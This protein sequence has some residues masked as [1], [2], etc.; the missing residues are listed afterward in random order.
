MHIAKTV[1]LHRAEVG[2]K[3]EEMISLDVGSRVENLKGV[4]YGVL[5]IVALVAQGREARDGDK[6]Q[7]EI[8]RVSGEFR[9]ADRAIDAGALILLIN[10]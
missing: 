10:S 1:L 8:A 5:R 7:A 2:A 6:A 9:Q 4:G 3:L